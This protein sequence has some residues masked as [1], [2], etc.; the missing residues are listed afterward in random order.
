MQTNTTRQDDS[1]QIAPFSDQVFDRIPVAD[2]HDILFDNGAIIQLFRDIVAR[3]AYQLDASPIGLVIGLG[4][5][6]RG[7]KGMVNIDDAVVIIGRKLGAQNL[8]IPS[9]HE[10]IDPLTRQKFQL[11]L[12]LFSFIR[13]P[14]GDNIEG[15]AEPLCNR[16]KV[17]MV[18]AYES[19]CPGEL[20]SGVPQ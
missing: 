19:N 6:K 3:S 14:D 13:R 20:S 1:L 17:T 12:F 2:T 7:Q 18:A 15:N 8:H 16:L 5:G 11:F 4:S 10:Q 9:Q